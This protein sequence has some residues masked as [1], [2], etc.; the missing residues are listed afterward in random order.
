MNNEVFC[1]W[2]VDLIR[3]LYAVESSAYLFGFIDE[4]RSLIIELAI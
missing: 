2:F 4:S 3:L 1:L